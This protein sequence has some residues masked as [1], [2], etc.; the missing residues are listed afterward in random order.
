[1]PGFLQAHFGNVHCSNIVTACAQDVGDKKKSRKKVVVGDDEE[2]EVTDAALMINEE[3]C[4]ARLRKSLSPATI[5]NAMVSCHDAH[6]VLYP[7]TYGNKSHRTPKHHS[8][9]L[10]TR[11]SGVSQYGTALE[12]LADQLKSAAV[13]KTD[14]VH[15]IVPTSQEE[16]RIL[17]AKWL[18]QV[19]AAILV[20]CKCTIKQLG[21]YLAGTN[22]QLM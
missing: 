22:W 21:P 9:F 13:S 11:V 10:L 20:A 18:Q 4:L 5:A 15:S 19:R 17:F 14:Q 16:W 3:K 8:C 7:V 6:K 1:M 2:A 12:Y